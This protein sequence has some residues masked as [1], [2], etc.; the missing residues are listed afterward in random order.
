MQEPMNST[1]LRCSHSWYRSRYCPLL[2]VQDGGDTT[3]NGTV[4]I[5]FRASPDLCHHVRRGIN[6]HGRAVT[7]ALC[8]FDGKPATAGFIHESVTTSVAFTD[9]STQNLSLLVTK[10]HPSAPMVFGL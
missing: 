1:I 5:Y 10:L 2:I 9:G 6:P 8:L 3:I 7:I 4:L